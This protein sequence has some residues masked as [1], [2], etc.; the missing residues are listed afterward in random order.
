MPIDS[1]IIDLFNR[2]EQ[3]WHEGKFGPRRKNNATSTVEA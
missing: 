1:K 2:W 3:V